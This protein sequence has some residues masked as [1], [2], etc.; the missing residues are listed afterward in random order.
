MVDY[1]CGS[2]V[3]GIAA[4]L[5][6]AR[7]VICVDHD[8]Q[9]L[10]ASCENA[11]RNGVLERIRVMEPRDYR[12]RP[13]DVVLAN[14]LAEPLIELAPVLLA[15]L[16]AKGDLVLSGLLDEQ[17]GQVAGAYRP[18]L[19]VMET[20]TRDGWVRLHGRKS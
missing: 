7:C 2:G 4:A 3:L 6:G 20:V 10:E 14:I 8:R 16:K 11:R 18:A 9:A 1:G 17:A 5:K 19:S 12:S 15:S 13:A